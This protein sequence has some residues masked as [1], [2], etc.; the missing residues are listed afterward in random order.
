[1]TDRD[2]RMMQSPQEWPAWPL[3]ALK[4]RSQ[5]DPNCL[6]MPRT[7]FLIEANGEVSP[8]VYEGN[9]WHPAFDQPIAYE[10][11]AAV[12]ADWMVD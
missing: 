3:L 12:A 5:K 11:L 1:M 4:H 2:L 10:S 7:G 6:G 8:V 9:I